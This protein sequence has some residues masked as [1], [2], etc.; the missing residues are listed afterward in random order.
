VSFHPRR[1]HV[2]ET[3]S[4]ISRH[5]RFDGSDG[6]ENRSYGAQRRLVDYGEW[7][8]AGTDHSLSKR[9][10]TGADYAIQKRQ[11]A[12][13]HNALLIAGLFRRS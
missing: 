8:F 12:G 1:Q 5:A 7:F 6:P 13:T 3:R 11:L 10:F 9:E 2:Q 4:G